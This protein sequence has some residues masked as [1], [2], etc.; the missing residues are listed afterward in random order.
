MDSNAFERELVDNI[1]L[2]LE[3]I[4]DSSRHN[5]HYGREYSESVGEE[6][7]RNPTEIRRLSIDH[8]GNFFQDPKFEGVWSDFEA[9]MEE[10]MEK[11]RRKRAESRSERRSE[12][13]ALFR[14]FNKKVLSNEQQ[15]SFDD[16]F[17]DAHKS[18]R[19]HTYR[20]LRKWDPEDATLAMKVNSS[21]KGFR[22]R[23]FYIRIWKLFSKTPFSMIK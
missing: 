1:P 20:N 7:T 22:V 9:A 14:D 5:L 11:R 3:H 18:G 8:R 19:F 6:S 2:K 21:D 15:S 13:E 16:D 12:R 10:M 17:F 4:D 23:T